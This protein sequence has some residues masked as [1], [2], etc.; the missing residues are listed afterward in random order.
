MNRLSQEVIYDQIPFLRV[1]LVE[2]ARDM[3]RELEAG[4]PGIS[5]QPR[6]WSG[7]RLAAVAEDPKLA[8]ARAGLLEMLKAEVL[9]YL[10]ARKGKR[11]RLSKRQVSDN[12][13]SMV[14]LGAG[15]RYEARV[16][17]MQR[18]CDQRRQMDFQEVMHHWLHYWLLVHAPASMLLLVWTA[19]HAVTGLFYY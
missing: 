9:P 15:E 16:D 8:E 3:Q 11:C 12:L 6:I 14:R 18:W 7:G 4:D 17:E 5:T 19:W 1:R 13:F 2:Q 10:Q